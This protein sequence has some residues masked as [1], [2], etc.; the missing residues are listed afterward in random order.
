MLSERWDMTPKVVLRA[1]LVKA[2]TMQFLYGSA[3][4]QSATVSILLSSLCLNKAKGFISTAK[5]LGT[6]QRTVISEGGNQ[7][8]DLSPLT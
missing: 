6:S 7:W 1:I 5:N 4:L 3:Y 2:S 8:L